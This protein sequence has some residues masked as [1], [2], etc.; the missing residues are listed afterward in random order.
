[1][2]MNLRRCQA[3]NG[4][5]NPKGSQKHRNFC[6][7]SCKQQPKFESTV[8]TKCPHG[9]QRSRCKQ[10]DGVS[11]CPHNTIRSI[12]KPC[13]CGSLCMHN[14]IRSICKPCGGGSLCMHNRIR[15][16]CKPCG[17]GSL[18]MH[19]G[20]APSASR[21]VVAPSACTTFAPSASRAVV[22]LSARTTSFATNASSVF[23]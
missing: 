7:L 17:G 15:S 4:D 14:R 1:V 6:G 2:K 19:N 11:I 9:N 22:A 23:P 20:F 3:C 18:C 10:C 8:R 12:C 16:I 13:G 5:Y 21:A